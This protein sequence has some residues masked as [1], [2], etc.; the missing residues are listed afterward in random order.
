MSDIQTEE[1][2]RTDQAKDAASNV[3]DEAGSKAGQVADQAKEQASELAGTAAQKAG[4]VV[5]TARDELRQR[6]VSEAETAGKRLQAVADELRV[7]SRASSDNGGTVAPVVG[8][9]AERIDRSAQRL[10]GG[11]VDQVI[12]DVKRFAR[13]RPGTFL[14]GAAGVGFVVGRLLRSADLAQLKE[15]AKPSSGQ[16]QPSLGNGQASQLASAPVSP[17]PTA[18]GSPTPSATPPPDTAASPGVPS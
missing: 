4:D 14:L 18:I 13:N 5:G 15:S 6:A 7:M 8:E 9:L 17:P 2:S 16:E 12:E 10:V 1:R 11:D 3:A